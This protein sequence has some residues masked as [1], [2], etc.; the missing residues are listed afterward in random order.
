MLS[1]YLCSSLSLFL[2][3]NKFPHLLSFK[4]H[5]RHHLLLKPCWNSWA[6]TISAPRAPWV[7]LCHVILRAVLCGLTHLHAGPM[8]HTDTLRHVFPLSSL[9]NT[10]HIW[11]TQMFEDQLAE[12][13]N[14]L[15]DE[16][17][18]IELSNRV[19]RDVMPVNAPKQTHK[20]YFKVL[21]QRDFY[22]ECNVN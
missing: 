5:L 19:L 3:W 2:T 15:T 17:P 18:G 13:M 4:I 11:I 1:F 16:P 14:S 9:H 10:S 21:N 12:Q 20:N 8:G 6:A 7:S 22:S